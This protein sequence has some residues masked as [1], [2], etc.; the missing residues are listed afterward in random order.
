MA[1]IGSEEILTRVKM[2]QLTVYYFGDLDIAADTYPPPTQVWSVGDGGVL[3]WTLDFTNSLPTLGQSVVVS[4]ADPTALALRDFSLFT[5]G[6]LLA[7]GVAGLFDS[8]RALEESL[9]TR[10]EVHPKR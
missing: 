8:L 3:E 9:S 7:T 2:I 5:A 10:M 6:L 1:R 4:L